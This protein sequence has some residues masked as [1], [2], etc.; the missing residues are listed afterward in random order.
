VRYL[1]SA[2][3][4]L[5][6][7][8]AFGQCSTTPIAADDQI[9]AANV[10][11]VVDVLA[12]DINLDGAALTV[13]TSG[14]TCGVPAS[15]DADQLVHLNIAPDQRLT[16]DCVV[17]YYTQTESGLTSDAARI[18]VDFVERLFEDSFESGDTSKWSF[19]S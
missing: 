14:N 7:I 3:F 6:S 2:I 19:S 5:C 15:V 1:L 17:F 10:A 13:S 16:A 11:V 12:N 18:E 4:L 9:N 8:P